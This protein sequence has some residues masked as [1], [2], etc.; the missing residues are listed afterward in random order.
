MT[1][2]TNFLTDLSLIVPPRKVFRLIGGERPVDVDVSVFPARAMLKFMQVM[3]GKAK[4]VA[5][6]IEE[7]VS[8][9]AEACKPKNPGITEDWLFDNLTFSQLSDFCGL[10][11]EYGQAQ[12]EE[13]N[14]KFTPKNKGGGESK[15]LPQQTSSST[16]GKSSHGRHQ[17]T[18]SK[19]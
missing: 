7:M 16:S 12:M 1:D 11:M 15:N 9:V 14:Q 17:T 13:Y 2:D 18:A 6:S 4:G 19:K 5:P 3:E 10:V 8:V